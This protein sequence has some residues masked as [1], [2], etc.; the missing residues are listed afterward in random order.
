MYIGIQGDTECLHEDR[1]GGES[2]KTFFGISGM[3][4]RQMFKTANWEREQQS[5]ISFSFC[6]V[7]TFSHFVLT[8]GPAK[9]FVLIVVS[10]HHVP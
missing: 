10:N 1:K 4:F 5:V 6:W 2:Q 9:P 3:G 8:L 7:T